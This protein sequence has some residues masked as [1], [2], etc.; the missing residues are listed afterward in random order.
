[1]KGSERL[2]ELQADDVLVSSEYG[3]NYWNFVIITDKDVTVA[4]FPFD[5]VEY[6]VSSEG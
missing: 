4:A 6:I 5:N 1:L 2:V 3:A